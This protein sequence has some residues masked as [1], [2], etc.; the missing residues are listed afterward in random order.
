MTIDNLKFDMSIKPEYHPIANQEPLMLDTVKKI[1]ESMLAV[2]YRADMPIV[3]FEEKYLDG[4]NRAIAAA[5]LGLTPTYRIFE[6]TYAEAQAESD[7]LNNDRR[8]RSKSQSAMMAAYIVVENREK[9]AL[10]KA[11]IR[12]K[13]PKILKDALS[14]E[15][16]KHHIYVEISHFLTA[17]QVAKKYDVSKNYV[18]KCIKYLTYREIDFSE[19]C[20][21]IFDGTLEMYQAENKYQTARLALDAANRP[22][23][24]CSE[25]QALL[26]EKIDLAKN[27]PE[28][29]AREIISYMQEAENKEEE[30]DELVEKIEDLTATIDD[31]MIELSVMHS[32]LNDVEGKG[33]SVP[34]KVAAA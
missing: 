21:N 29:A 14:R 17:E 19:M 28:S 34:T 22:A 33:I 15:M 31:L 8:H 2:G 18:E 23:K 5:A 4:R 26:Y 30:N 9:V 1:A 13:N 11:E 25:E 3:M 27:H 7:R 20:R 10:L 6:G 32:T 16:R 12:E 24:E